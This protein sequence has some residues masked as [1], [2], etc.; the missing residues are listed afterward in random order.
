MKG[1]GDG[2]LEVGCEMGSWALG[3]W[4]WEFDCLG[5]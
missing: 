1:F 2:D 3:G 5:D 4:V